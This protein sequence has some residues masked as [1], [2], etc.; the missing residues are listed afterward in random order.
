MTKCTV[1]VDFEKINEILK[2]YNYEKS[3]LIT[4]LQKVQEIYKFL[5]ED[6]ITY[7]GEHIEGLSPATVYGVATFYA[8]FSLEP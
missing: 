3:S 5:P 7:I 1:K 6:A 8:Q 2:S 4:I